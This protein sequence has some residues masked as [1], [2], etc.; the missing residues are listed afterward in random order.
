[1]SFTNSNILLLLLL[2]PVV[3][4]IGWPRLSYRRRRDSISLVIRLVL[5]TLLILGLAGIQVQQAADKLAVVFL[6]D[7]SDSMSPA[8]QSAA[9]NY[10][11]LATEAMTDKD[12]AAVVVFGADALVE[13]PMT[14]K[15]ELIQ[16]GSD[17]IRLN[18]DLAEAM[19]LG[20]ALFPADTAKRMVVLSDG[21]QTIGDAEEVARLAAATDVQID[22]VPLI[23]GQDAQQ[24]SGPEILV[25]D[26]RVPTTVNEGEEFDLTVTIVSNRRDV[27]LKCACCRRVGSSIVRK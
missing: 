15:L 21:K 5:L 3:A 16:I 2:L 6:I 25:K 20:L 17:P 24:V 27:S 4:V 7:M 22:Y 8:M 1:M 9:I 26:V 14:E 19:R 12:Q 11:R 23:G 13:A 10:V 18:T